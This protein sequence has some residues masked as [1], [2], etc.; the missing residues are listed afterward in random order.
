MLPLLLD[1][2][3]RAVVRRRNLEA[4]ALQMQRVREHR[5]QRIVRIAGPPGFGKSTLLREI[6]R[7][8]RADGWLAI[9]VTCGTSANASALLFDV[10]SAAFRELGGSSHAYTGGLDKA[11]ELVGVRDGREPAAR[12]GGEPIAPEIVVSR[13]LEGIGSDR[14]VLMALDDADAITS[15]T[16]GAL[17]YVM[18]YL[19]ET[20]T[21]VVYAHRD[22]AP[23]HAGLPAPTLEIALGPLDDDEASA[24]VRAEYPAAPADVHRALIE[25]ARGAPADLVLLASQ[26]R[27]DGA[28][29]TDDVVGSVQGTVTREL[30]LL[31]EPTRTF[32][33]YCALIGAPVEET[34]LAALYPDPAQLAALITTAARRYMS[35]SA[36]V[37]TF[38]HEV[39][40]A[41]IRGT[42]TLEAP[43]RKNIIAALVQLERG[44][45]EDYQRIVDHAEAIGDRETWHEYATRL[46][47]GAYALEHWEQAAAAY[48]SALSVRW[49]PPE[50]Y[51][52]FFRRFATA[53]RGMM[54]GEEAE[55]LIVRALRHGIELGISRR[56]GRLTATL[57]AL[58]T[59][60]EEPARA[61]ATFE[62]A[63]AEA[64]DDADAS[65]LLPAIAATYAN[66]A[67]ER[68]F[69]EIA[70]RLAAAPAVIP[71][72]K[73]SFHQ[74]EALLHARLGRHEAAKAALSTAR[75]FSLSEQSGMDYSVPLIELF[76]DFQEHGCPALDHIAP[77]DA[78]RAEAITGYWNYL[79]L[80]G[81]V[82]RGRWNEA[83]SRLER[84]NPDR[85]P[86]LE[87]RLLATPAVAAAA[88][89]GGTVGVDPR[90][91][92]LL[93]A[94]SR[95]GLGPSAFQ[96]ACWLL[97]A[98]SGSLAL[99]REL[100]RQVRAFR[101][102]PLATDLI[103][104]TPVALALYAGDEDRALSAELA[105]EEI[106][107][108]S[109]W[110][111]AQYEFSR[112]Y[113]R[114]VLG[115]RDG[116]ALLRGAAAQ[117]E[118]LGATLFAE[119]AATA[120]TRTAARRAGSMKRRAPSVLTRRE[121]QIAGLVADGK[122]NRE[123]AQALFLSER[124]VEVH[125]SN[126]FAK[127]DLT[128]RTQL[129]RYMAN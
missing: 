81:E 51:V 65:E 22:D 15:E 6:V 49:P 120:A 27:A 18:S 50:R 85:F 114:H 80:V 4:V 117:F 48:R 52:S 105:A 99:R 9:S 94:A 72:A 8:A 25:S 16:R 5:E 92:A 128:S 110:L 11:L 66:S 21:F 12:A 97:A 13:L 41:A 124:T 70:A 115:R 104:F 78:R 47:E 29:S 46:A 88:L 60:L 79:H 39:I 2:T 127:L 76:V 96:L 129:A 125:V 38:R 17:R 33:Q 67:D 71:L 19:S 7:R 89:S 64:Y 111:R 68:R 74:S 82:A 31:D 44:R 107:P 98:R 40:P 126:V 108:C 14:P 23:P 84:L 91:V 1:D 57:I 121:Q 37:L 54:R 34:V 62:R 112:A 55:T 102:R 100:A 61:I 3:G 90:A 122:R 59:E 75:S 123:I 30:S 86:A 26:A 101:E 36:G 20:P 118:A 113:S 83:A 10:A 56:L 45:L 116:A 58:Q 106:V 109:R 73:A 35:V 77:E 32:L 63:G 87:Q 69:A 93:D 53:L 43:L 42:I 95:H 28:R 24:I 103:C 119:L